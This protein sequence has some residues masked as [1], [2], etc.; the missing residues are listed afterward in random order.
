MTNVSAQW[1]TT[2]PSCINHFLSTNATYEPSIDYNVSTS[3]AVNIITNINASSSQNLWG[4]FVL[5]NCTAGASVSAA[6]N[7]TSWIVV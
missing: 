3:T 6:L 5:K 4:F 7:F 2:L 1:N